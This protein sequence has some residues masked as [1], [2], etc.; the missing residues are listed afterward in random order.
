MNLT[1]NQR[2]SFMLGLMIGRRFCSLKKTTGVVQSGTVVNKKP[3]SVN[4]G[5]V[6]TLK[7]GS[8][9]GV[10][11]ELVKIPISIVNNSSY[12]EGVAGFIV[13]MGYDPNY[14]EYVDFELDAWSGELRNVRDLS[15]AELNEFLSFKIPHSYS[16]VDDTQVSQGKLRVY[17]QKPK[18]E[19]LDLRIGYATFRVKANVPDSMSTLYIENR[20]G[21]GTGT[22]SELLTLRPDGYYYIARNGKPIVHVSGEISLT[23]SVKPPS[24]SIVGGGGGTSSGG[25]YIGGGGGSG[26]GG[27]YGGSVSIGGGFFVGGSGGGTG[28]GNLGIYVGGTLVDTIIFPVVKGDNYIDI[29]QDIVIPPGVSGEISWEIIVTPD[30]EDADW[31]IFIPAFGLKIDITVEIPREDA[32]TIPIPPVFVGGLEKVTILDNHRILEIII[33]KPQEPGRYGDVILVKDGYRLKAIL[34]S[35][36][37]YGDTIE[38]KDNH[39]VSHFFSSTLRLCDLVSIADSVKVFVEKDDTETDIE[40]EVEGEVIKIRLPDGVS[41]QDLESLKEHSFYTK[42]IGDLV[43]TIEG[44]EM[45]E[46]TSSG[47]TSTD[48]V[49]V[50]DGVRITF[51]I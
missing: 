11:G 37:S 5:D 1:E 51:S 12:N 23:S 33:P 44:T 18:A 32:G 8:K 25:G 36:L 7:Y 16:F 22:G 28:T 24:Y 26:G 3:S 13:D 38:I 48:G 4:K 39:G 45:K 42:S 27:G 34:S 46:N 30:D 49:G 43:V 19:Q 40:I 41:I 2:R 6:L 21:K 47:L 15:Q 9:N 17:G 20:A 50:G 35:T 29:T 14:L 10:R 31:Y